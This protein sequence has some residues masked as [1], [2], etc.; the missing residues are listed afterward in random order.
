MVLEF[1]KNKYVKEKTVQAVIKRIKK[2]VPGFI[3][4]S[5]SSAPQMKRYNFFYRQ[6]NKPT[7][8]LS[9]RTQVSGEIFLCVSYIRK[10]ARDNQVP[11]LE[12]LHR[13]LIHGLL[14]LSGYDH[15]SVASAKT[16]FQLQEKLVE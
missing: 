1:E 8:V 9:V 10:Q 5:F 7:D 4:I 13:L 2:K 6:K 14:H 12:E 11:F 16:M 3:F 15:S